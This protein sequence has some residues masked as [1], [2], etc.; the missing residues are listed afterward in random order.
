VHDWHCRQRPS[1]AAGLSKGNLDELKT[2]EL[3]NGRLAMVA[4]IGFVGQH[5][6]NGVQVL[7]A[8]PVVLHGEV[9]ASQ[10]YQKDQYA[11]MVAAI[12]WL[13][14]WHSAAT[15]HAKCGAVPGGVLWFPA[16]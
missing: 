1:P 3:K 15:M 16:P 2:K 4:F 14:T 6:A 13:H 8:W 10:G 11:Q 5:A 7:H 12:P 9:N